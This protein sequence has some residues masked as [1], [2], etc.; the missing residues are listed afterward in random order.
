MATSPLTEGA[1]GAWCLFGDGILGMANHAARSNLYIWGGSRH[2]CFC[3]PSVQ[4]AP[5]Q[6]E[7]TRQVADLGAETGTRRLIRNG[8]SHKMTQETLRHLRPGIRQRLQK[9]GCIGKSRCGTGTF[10]ERK[11][12]SQL[13]G[14][15]SA[16]A[17]HIEFSINGNP[18]RARAEPS[19][20]LLDH[21]RAEHGLTGTKEG[22]NEGDCGACTVLV[23]NRVGQEI[24]HR[25]VNACILLLPQLH[26]KA[27]R[28][29]EGLARADGGPNCVQK[30][31]V[32]LHA[33]QC[34]FCTPGFVVSLVAGHLNRARNH[35]DVVAGNLCRCTGYA[36]I[37]RA[38]ETA[39]DQR[40]P[41]W[42]DRIPDEIPDGELPVSEEDFHVP[43]SIDDLAEWLVAN[44]SATIVA[45][46]TDVGLWITKQL[47]CIKPLCF[48]AEVP[49]L[50]TVRRRDG[51]L[52]IGACV[53]LAEF[54]QFVCDDH[55]S[56]AEL[57][58]RFGSVQ[59]RNSA[60]IG[61]NVA[62]GSP[63]G[64]LSPAL[65]ALDARLLLRRGS[66][67]RTIPIED[68]FLGYGKQ[69][70]VPGEFL[71]AI[72]IPETTGKLRCHKLSKRF[73]QDISAVCGCFN[74]RVAAGV[75]EYARLAYGGMA[76][77]PRR[78]REAEAAL[79]GHPWNRETVGGA[80]DALSRDFA[81]ISDMRASAGYRMDVA[82]NM[83]LRT[84]LEDSS[85]GVAANVL[86]VG[87]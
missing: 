57:V 45:G 3:P 48:I 47:R 21:I 79:I 23:S 30:A 65:I 62:N 20:T 19:T 44:P 4:H 78:A 15:R 38:A 31:M 66:E 26:G 33:S 8:K 71:Q 86:E 58:R 12:A 36:P 83:L 34:G 16:M 46:A 37:V 82:R 56:L 24:R 80:M 76:A 72:N 60:T 13:D 69:D 64:D 81:P 32:D 40:L 73:D 39:F 5:A 67:T 49:E 85:P 18:F 41:E 77:T 42:S 75:V 1:G 2:R 9:P 68:F 29:V 55:P 25:A 14:P 52:E 22:C 61:G 74:I 70:I 63:I 6:G 50:R 35:D 11:A 53:T 43:H 27:V 87:P 54:G 17:G 59:V 7:C 28:T 84:F 51:A 10:R